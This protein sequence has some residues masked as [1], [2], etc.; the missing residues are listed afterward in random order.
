MSAI[1]GIFYRNGHIVHHEQIKK[2]NDSITHRGPDN[3]D[4][5]CDGSIA[6][7]HQMLYTTPE[8]LH[9]HLPLEEDGLVITADARIDNR[10]VLSKSLDIEN[11]ENVSDSYYILKSYQKWGENCT[12]KLL[13]DFA[14]AIW[15]KKKEEL[16]CARD[17]IGVKPIYYYLSN[18]L[19]AFATEIKALLSIKEIKFK[20]NEKTLASYL[21]VITYDKSTFYENIY[22]FTPAH[23]L[24]IDADQKKWGKYWE[25][26]PESKIILD[27]EED[28]RKKFREIF[29]ESVNCRLRSAFP[30]GFE[31]S[32]GLDSSSVACMAKNILKTKKNTYL[33]KIMTFSFIFPS[34]PQ[35]DESYYIK[36][37]TDTGGFEPHFIQGDEYSPLEQ[38]KTML[39]HLEEPFVNPNLT[40]LW[41]LYK[42]MQEKNIRIVLSGNGGDQIIS[43]GTNFF[44][45]LAIKFKWKKLINE[46]YSYTNRYNMDI[47]KIFLKTVLIPIIPEYPKR[48]IRPYVNKDYKT[49][50]LNKNFKTR[51]KAN[52]YLN[53]KFLKPIAEA[54]T[55]KKDH[56]MTITQEN[57]EPLELID[58]TASAFSMESRYPFL[59][60]RLIEFCYAIPTEIKFKFGWSRYI[61]RIAMNDIIPEVNQWRLNKAKLDHY[62][63]KNLL[64]FEKNLLDEIIIYDNK[65]IKDYVDLDKLKDTYKNYCNGIADSD[66]IYS[67]WLTSLLSIWFKKKN[68]NDMRI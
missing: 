20:L 65:I 35:I 9:E 14:F 54:N 34:I 52:E 1:T 3:S 29:E 62:Y 48:H 25:L 53:E 2:M 55:A 15:D 43:S 30:I 21:M 4:V 66:S 61:L 45:D 38:I 6:L 28:Y 68:R 33:N 17:H 63:E 36:N 24:K 16:F 50:I 32:G 11:N 39:W 12:E 41:N 19:F 56:Y 64:L 47:F 59:D 44:R 49:S 18:D 5:W 60:K 23:S 7:G 51:I 42:K 13:G 67:I 27:S 40:I 22:S 8:S 46:L 26:N 58:R 57:L 10:E 31:L 37:V